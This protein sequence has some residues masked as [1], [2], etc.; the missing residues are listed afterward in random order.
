MPNRL[1]LRTNAIMRIIMTE[2]THV[3]ECTGKLDHLDTLL[4]DRFDLLL[5][6][7]SPC[8][9]ALALAVQ[10]SGCGNEVADWKDQ[11]NRVVRAAAF[12]DRTCL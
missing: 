12:S 10:L 4:S 6:D 11:G 2:R 3:I 1:R 9:D 5:G 8:L 7:A